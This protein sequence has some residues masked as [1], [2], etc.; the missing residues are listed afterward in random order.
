MSDGRVVIEIE[1]DDNADKQI[2]KMEK[3]LNKAGES[4]GKSLEKAYN[5]AVKDI[6]NTSNRLKNSFIGAFKAM[7][8]I[9]GKALKSSFNF[10]K[11]MPATVGSGLKVLASTVKTGFVNA[12][13]AAITSV[14]KLGTS[15]KNTS[16]NIKNGFF[17]VAKAVQSGVKTA[18]AASI[19]TIKA[20]PSTVKSAGTFIKSSFISAFQVSKQAAISFG[21]SVLQTFKAIPSAIKT[22][23][24]ALKSG[25]IIAFKAS[26]VAVHAS[27]KGIISTIK[28]I[29]AA[30]KF[31]GGTVKS[32]FSLMASAAKT[33]GSTIKTALITGFNEAKSGAKTA[34]QV[35]MSAIKMLGNAAKSA[36]LAVKNGLVGGFKAA[37]ATAK[38]AFSGMRE[39]FKQSVEQP[40]QQARVSI[41]RLAAAFG[42][43]AATKNVIGSAIG[44]VDTIDTATKSLKVLTGSAK[45]AELIMNDLTDAIDGTPIAL[46][47]VAL[48]AK[49]MVAAGMQAKSVKPVF[50]AIADA[51]YGVG[52]GAPS[53]DQMVDAISSLQASSIAYSD[54][55]NR[56]VDSGVPAWQIL[57]NQTGK[58]VGDMKK[59][60]SKGMLDSNK[61]IKLLVDGI[62]NGTTGIAGNTAK[63]AGLAKTAGNTIS[64]SFANMKTAAVKSMANVATNL[65]GPIIASLTYL[66]N[67]FKDLA[68]YTASPEFQ[69]KLTNFVKK[70][71]EIIPVALKLAPTI[72]KLVAAFA[73]FN[74]LSSIFSKVASLV[75]AFKGLASS[76][77]LLGTILSGIKGGFTALSGAIGSSAGAFALIGA[78]VAAVIAVFV[79]MYKSFK[80]NTANIRNVMAGVWEA[81]KNSFGKTIEVFKQILTALKPVGSAFGGIL[82]YIGVAVWVAFGSALAIVADVLQIL[83]RVTLV[84][85]KALQGVY[86]AVKAAAQAIKGDFKGAKKSIE[87]SKDAFVDAG[88]AIK[89]AFNK[90]NY[91]TTGVIKSFGDLGKASESAGKK[92]ATSNKEIQ[93]SLKLVSATTKQTENTVS[94]ANSS[95]DNLLNS[96]NNKIGGKLNEKTKSFLTAVKKTY[97]SYQKASQA[98]ADKYTSA[99]EKAEDLSGAKRKA[100]IAKANTDLV[101]AQQSN[102]QKLLTVQ[103]DY[104]KMLSS[105]KW[106]TGQALT[107]QQRKFLQQQTSNIAAEL[108][109]QNELYVKANLLRLQNG[110][111]L[112]ENERNTSIEVQNSL[113]DSRK[114]AAE[115]GENALLALKKK[116]AEAGTKTEKAN[117]QIQIDAQR[118][119]NGQ[120]TADL[121]NWA[122]EM[123]TIFANGSQLNAT[124]FANGLQQLGNISKPQLTALWYNF[125]QTS[126]SIDNTL[127]GLA[128][129]MGQR[130][131]QGAQ[132]FVQAIQSGDYIGAASKINNDV[133]STIKGLPNE[134]FLQGQTGKTNF[135]QAIKSG[136]FKGAGA[137]LR[138]GVKD[139]VN[140]LTKE[141]RSK[142]E[143]AG[144][145]HASG[146]SSTKGKNSAAGKGIKDAAKNGTS[147]SSGFNS[148]GSLNG[149]AFASGVSGKKAEA[150][151]AGLGLSNSATSGINTSSAHSKGQDFGQGFANGISSMG[152]VVGQAAGAMVAKALAATQ[153][154]QDSHSPSKKTKKLGKDYGSGFSLG[155][156]SKEKAVKK[157]ASS[158]VEGALGTQKQIKRLSSTL[159]DKISTAVTTGLHT[160]SMTKSQRNRINAL[161]G[162]DSTI[163]KQTTNLAKVAK[164]R[165]KVV[166]Q[167]KKS[168]KKLADI[169]KSAK[170]YA[171]SIRD[172]ALSFGSITSMDKAKLSGTDIIKGLDVRYK[173]IKSFQQNVAK[174]RKKGLS[175]QIIQQI[176]DAG[177]EDGSAYA[178]ALAKSNTKTIKAINKKQ[179]S[180]SSASKSLGNTAYN[181]MY[182]SGIYAAKGLVKGLDSQKKALD[183]SAKR[184]ANTI[185][186]SVRKALKIHSPSRIAVEIGKFFGVG[187]GNGID[188]T[189]KYNAVKATNLG[190]TVSQSTAKAIKTPNI[191]MPSLTKGNVLGVKTASPNRVQKNINQNTTN[192]MFDDSG[193]IKAIKSS[194]GSV[195]VNVGTDKIVK[196]VNEKNANKYSSDWYMQGGGALV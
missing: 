85:I 29:P 99:M 96:S 164:K 40:A 70:M 167:L 76:G 39:S 26:V 192:N 46:D 174:L 180:I 112:S 102:N 133:I 129:I 30:A 169:Q 2:S 161:K 98:S 153:K 122:S 52:D 143:Q 150:A 114:K 32:A 100:A 136:D 151:R 42:L 194:K 62:E 160:K 162:I 10:I 92:V 28:G 37:S 166:E 25:L 134:M 179:K 24:S 115:E 33:T 177:I 34:G 182:Q 127:S 87:Q 104:G 119:K 55:I 61:A 67:A 124:T 128:A 5:E 47:A 82:K 95:I 176:L 63:M 110:K 173:A 116:K 125:A 27:V 108:S 183:K 185:S 126:T 171:A 43:I 91:A 8:S 58:S 31:V 49:K 137:Y 41:L 17:S 132:A 184:I 53:I 19:Q 155:I 16:V 195:I 146:V 71:K 81:V 4:A 144:N 22:V 93:S 193:I 51:A 44:R 35:G 77:G 7:G 64:G 83:A 159:K 101:S 131:G 190:N 69:A 170:D 15:I 113:Y 147:D 186:K 130:G 1:L 59:D 3:D 152:G 191:K 78:A 117:Y 109:K 94:K 196:Q 154:K 66:K 135:I 121:N 68:T 50:T 9:G 56:L 80:E 157:A 172:N 120:L 38:G 20:I 145:S 175:N 65:K 138:T 97:D 48:G 163:A 73:A 45:D 86:Y 148:K 142:G 18:V 90:D 57:A 187:L 105:N 188:R 13:K 84:V 60:V 54:D 21:K 141:L 149:G 165:D 75:G 107:E 181:S 6:A 106:V 14:K 79:G 111:T 123:N 72:L 89:D 158:L 23:G 118:K 156:A 168:Q 189:S 36:G 74:V 178:K 139:G 12:S 88:Q 11:Q 103:A 140:P